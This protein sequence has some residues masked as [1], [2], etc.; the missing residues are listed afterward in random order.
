MLYAL[1]ALCGILSF[2][3][4]RSSFYPLK[5]LAGFSWWGLLFYWLTNPVDAIARGDPTDIAIIG[6]LIMA[7]M[8]FMLWGMVGRKGTV[9]IQ[10]EV[11]SSGNIISR[12]KKYT[13]HKEE[14]KQG[15]ESN[16]EYRNKVRKAL[17]RGETR[18]KR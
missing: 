12:I 17:H 10:D 2:L 16:L 8:L 5:W 3:S 15:A 6:I 14:P 7:G 11:S 1:I 9:D 13:A 4:V 18:R